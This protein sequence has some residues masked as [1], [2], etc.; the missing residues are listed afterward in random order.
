MRVV[1]C[2]ES[3]ALAAI[4]STLKQLSTYEL[5]HCLEGELT[6]GQFR[7]AADVILFD[8]NHASPDL[9]TLLRGQGINVALIGLNFNDMTLV[10]HLSRVHSLTSVEDLKRAIQGIT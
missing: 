4:A 8:Q 9:K 2:G 7:L 3:I 1:I 10:S 6:T 5:H